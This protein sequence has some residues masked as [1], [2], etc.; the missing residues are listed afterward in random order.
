MP[1]PLRVGNLEASATARIA[2]AAASSRARIRRPPSLAFANFELPAGSES[3]RAS[4]IAWASNKDGNGVTFPSKHR[5]RNCRT[6]SPPSLKPIP[7]NSSLASGIPAAFNASRNS[8]S[9]QRSDAIPAGAPK[10]SRASSSNS[11]TFTAAPPT[12]LNSP[13]LWHR[14][15]RSATESRRPRVARSGSDGNAANASNRPVDGQ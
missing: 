3:V 4:D 11:P 10:R 15:Y 6:S 5:R 14:V 12:W 2:A 8:A 9:R 7:R 13:R 1:L